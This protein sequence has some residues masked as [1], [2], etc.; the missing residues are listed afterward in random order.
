[1]STLRKTLFTLLI[2]YTA[3]ISNLSA[4]EATQ[5][6]YQSEKLQ[7]V[8]ETPEGLNV[9]ESS[10]Y[11]PA[12]K[13][14]YVSNV[15]GNPDKKD[16]VGFISKISDKG[17]FVEKE[18]VKGLN[19][20]KGIGIA[21][22][23]LYV[24]DINEVVEISLKTAQIT[25][26]YKTSRAHSFNDI[27]TDKQ[28]HVYVSEMQQHLV[29]MVGKDSLEVFAGSDQIA[30][31]NGICDYGKEVILGS[32][33]NLIAIDKETKAIRVLAE[34]T[35]YL[36]GIVVVGKNKIVTSDWKGK[37]QLIEPGKPIE[38]LLNTTS[39]KINA[40]DLGWIPSQQILL[41][42]TFSNNKIVAFKL[43]L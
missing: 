32:K 14:I 18:W 31:V 4:Q 24:T 39:Q 38:V 36:D 23:K 17:K 42:P 6:A 43:K 37:V 5:P 3:T 28:G 2:S 9:P 10:C 33:G 34:K 30:S 27:T 22:G 1:M 20:P 12:D 41:V 16:G 13:T 15:V 19:A 40:A 7:K 21:N 29:F 11:N 25:K 8:W 26:R 35:G